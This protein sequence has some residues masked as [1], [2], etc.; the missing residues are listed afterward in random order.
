MILVVG[1]RGSGLFS[2]EDPCVKFVTYFHSVSQCL[3]NLFPI[4]VGQEGHKHWVQDFVVGKVF[5]RR[6]N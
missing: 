6:K 4:T 5:Q 3:L 1:G 2:H